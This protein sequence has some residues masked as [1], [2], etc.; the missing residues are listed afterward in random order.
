MTLELAT[1]VGNE[2]FGIV[3]DYYI[4]APAQPSTTVFAVYL[5]LFLKMMGTT[6]YQMYLLL[7][8]RITQKG[9]ERLCH[10]VFFS[11]LN[12]HFKITQRHFKLK[13]EQK[14]PQQIKIK[15][16]LAALVTDEL[17]GAIL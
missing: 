11:R 7:L 6:N 4:T 15:L 17:V 8:K 5:A 12:Q 16:L 2:F 14:T 9:V 1:S 3:S 10:L 13:G